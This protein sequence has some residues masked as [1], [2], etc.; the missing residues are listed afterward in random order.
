MT[1]S[2]SSADLDDA[3]LP[4]VSA[5][6]PNVVDQVPVESTGYRSDAPR[7]SSNKRGRKPDP[8]PAGYA[9][10]E[11]AI[12]GTAHL[13]QTAAARE[14]SKSRSWVCRMRA[15]LGLAG[16]PVELRVRAA[17][18]SS[19]EDAIRATAALDDA[20]AAERFAVTASYIHGMRIKLGLAGTVE[21]RVRAAGYSSVEDAIQATAELP[22]AAA[23][24]QLTM[25][26]SKVHAMR[27][28][29]GLAGSAIERRVRSAGYTSVRQAIRV[30]AHLS[31]ASA[32]RQI[33]LSPPTVRQLRAKWGYATTTSE[34]PRVQTSAK[35]T[36]GRRGR[37]PKPPPAGYA[38]I[39]DAI[40]DTAQMTLRAAAEQLHRSQTTVHRMRARLGLTGST[41]SKRI[42]AAGFD[43][44]EEAIRGTAKLTVKQAAERLNLSTTLVQ[45]LRQSLG[46]TGHNIDSRVRAAGFGSVEEAIRGTAELTV[47][48]AAE[49]LTISTTSVQRLRAKHGLT[50]G[51]CERLARARGFDGVEDA[52]R[53]TALL[54][55]KDAAAQLGY[56]VT[57]LHAYRRTY[58]LGQANGPHCTDS[59][60][61]DACSSTSS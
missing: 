34:Q 57:T 33:N 47:Q 11:D 40:R 18:Y 14:L 15:K 21:Q 8:P 54:H 42:R 53:S 4:A 25:T 26:P 16:K 12:R 59:N 39:E 27:E 31:Q 17:G 29:L 51:V 45:D 41:A 60:E 50:G 22:E 35:P 37:K 49:R 52:I 1:P 32:A 19:V 10:I 48:Q 43:S 24:Q 13:S 7:A 28:K 30:T 56:S 38:T 61:P 3:I 20:V 9:T 46:L 2:E 55:Y 36:S 5:H 23:A 6:A 58:G 44:A